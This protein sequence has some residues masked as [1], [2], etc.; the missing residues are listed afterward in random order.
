MAAMDIKRKVKPS[1]RFRG[2]VLLKSLYFCLDM[3]MEKKMS[4]DMEEEQRATSDDIAKDLKAKWCCKTGLPV[5]W[6][7]PP[8][9]V[10]D[11]AKAR[12]AIRAAM[13][14]QE[15]HTLFSHALLLVRSSPCVSIKIS[16]AVISSLFL[17][18]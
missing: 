8:G 11:E 7:T 2:K 4:K 6:L 1:V 15:L 5:S 3:R 13:T 17:P 10:A 16:S 18:T 14:E 12:V 9:T